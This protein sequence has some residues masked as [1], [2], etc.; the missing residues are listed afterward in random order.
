MNTT[1]YGIGR[2]RTENLTQF[3][4]LDKNGLIKALQ[5]ITEKQF[6]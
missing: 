5:P 1:W 3:Q 4:N 2:Y 6:V